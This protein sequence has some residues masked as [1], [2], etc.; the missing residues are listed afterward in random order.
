MTS[1]TRY[2][3]RRIPF[4]HEPS[5]DDRER[6]TRPRDC[7]GPRSSTTDSYFMFPAPLKVLRGFER[8]VTHLSLGVPYLVRCRKGAWRRSG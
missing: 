1:P 7:S 8:S 2:T 3:V 6:G 5:S 4:D